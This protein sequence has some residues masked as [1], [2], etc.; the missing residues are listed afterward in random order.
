MITEFKA[1]VQKQL[2]AAF[3]KYNIERHTPAQIQITCDIRGQCCGRA[4]HKSGK[5]YLKFNPEAISKYWDEMVKNTIPHEIAHIIC[6]MRPFLGKKHDSG[7]K[8][9]CR[10]LGGNDSRTHSMNLTSAKKV[11][12]YTYK[13]DSG[14]LVTLKSGR[15]N[16]LQR[17]QVGWYQLKSTGEKITR[18]HFVR[19]KYTPIT[20]KV[21]HTNRVPTLRGTSKKDQAQTIFN[22]NPNMAR[23]T[24]INLFMTE[25]HLT[26]SGASTYYYNCKKAS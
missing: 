3:D 2:K 6:Y 14:E 22:A 19:R 7:W 12:E 26:K 17:G 13:T 5:Y 15:H 20:P 9:V 11:N 18:S 25:V 23:S 4:G 10:N 24:M 8:Q 1:E 21:K 16:K